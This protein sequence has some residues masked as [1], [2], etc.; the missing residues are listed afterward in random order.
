MYNEMRLQRQKKETEWPMVPLAVCI[1]N[2]SPVAVNQ[3]NF[4]RWILL[5]VFILGL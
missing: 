3:S 4:I 1:R 5:T 2:E